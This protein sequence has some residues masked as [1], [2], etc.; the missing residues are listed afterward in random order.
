[1]DLFHCM[2]A[3]RRVVE[4][5]GFSAAARDLGLATAT[6]SSAVAQLEERLAT[7]LLLR[8]TRRMSLTAEGA[9]YYERCVR[10]LDDLEEL[11]GSLPG[12]DAAPTGT[13]K[14]NAPM[15]FGLLHLAPLVPELLARWPA[16]RIDLALTDRFVDVVEE[17]VD[18]AVRVS[19]ELPDSATLAVQRLASARQVLCASPGYLE[20]R[21]VPRTPADLAAHECITYSLSRTPG[22]W[23]L[24]GPTGTTRVPV[25]GRVVANSS[26]VIRQALLAGLGLSLIPSFYVGPE[27]ASGQL[28]VVLD[29][30]PAPPLHVSAVYQRSRY[31]APRVRALIGL[32]RE[33]WA[34]ADWVA[35]AAARERAPRGAMD[36]DGAAS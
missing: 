9:A 33:R 31:L 19:P 20:A 28:R 36:A 27:L 25:T 4:L 10:L 24:A 8:T 34:V 2:R 13:L 17:A 14:V 35:P 22:V 5:Q 32:L 26:L 11:E 23:E 7:K 6:V 3:F 30:H 15:S 1:M 12:A 29:D 18:V 16:L 21:G